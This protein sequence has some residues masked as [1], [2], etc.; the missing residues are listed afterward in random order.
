MQLAVFQA[1]VLRAEC[2][3]AALARVWI[4]V[5]IDH[6]FMQFRFVFESPAT[7]STTKFLC[8]L[9]SSTVLLKFIKCLEAL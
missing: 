9:V 7:L 4:Q 5:V 2:F 3:L 8:Q 6:V 1:G